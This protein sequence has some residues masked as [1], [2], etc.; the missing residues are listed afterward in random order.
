MVKKITELIEIENKKFLD[1]KET[2]TNIF[3][4][5]QIVLIAIGE[6]N[7]ETMKSINEKSEK[8]NNTTPSTQPNDFTK[9]LNISNASIIL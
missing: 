8:Y 9:E 2:N 6:S 4:A 3:Y 1:I 5:M 7:G